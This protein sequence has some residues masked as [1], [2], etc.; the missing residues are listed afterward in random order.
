MQHSRRFKIIRTIIFIILVA[1][2]LYFFVGK[3]KPSAPTLPAGWMP[4]EGAGFSISYP[5]MY[6]ADASHDYQALGPGKDIKGVSFTIPENYTNGTNLASDSFIGVEQLPNAGDCSASAF[7]DNP[8][9]L[10]AVKENGVTYSY[11]D[12][13]DPAAGNIYAEKVYVIV[14]SSPCTAVRYL[15]HSGN[16]YNYPEGAVKAFDEAKLLAEFDA[17]RATLLLKK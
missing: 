9:N 14:G 5:S 11:A 15:I 8:G 17:I 12:S 10:K 7:L 2:G 4:Y 6:K 16:I 3:S 1:V 13:T